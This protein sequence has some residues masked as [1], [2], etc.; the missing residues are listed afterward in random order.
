MS[1]FL[2]HDISYAQGQYNM[3]ADPYPAIEMKMSGYYYGSKTPYL[4]VQAARNYSNAIRLGKVPILYHYAGG[5]DPRAEAEYFINVCAPLAAGDVYELDYELNSS[6]GPPADPDGWCRAFADRVHELTG[7][8]PIFYTYTSLFLQHNKF[9]KTMEVCSLYIAD[10][11]FTPDQN[12]PCG[13]PYIM[14]QY[15]DSPVDTNASFISL[16]TLRKYAYGYQEP[17]PPPPAPEPTTT[18]TTVEPAPE[19]TTTTTT[20]EAP[21]PPVPDPTTTTTT[22]EVMEPPTSTTTTT[23]TQPA[24]EEKP[25]GLNL[26]Q[27]V[28]ARMFHT[29]W[30]SFTAIFLLGIS[31]LTSTLLSV[32]SLSDAKSAAYAVA[33]AVVA[34]ALSAFKNL[35]APPKEVK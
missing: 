28:L 9:P 24:I 30:Q 22:T 6:M 27:A 10:Y 5:A 7:K 20:T 15:S 35:I 11:R 25:W 19:P 8:Y 4:D 17:T 16:D 13:H 32:H 18:T 26:Y 31:G 33:A 1:D 14:H 12:V 29:F 23:T 21:A 3:D 2:F 34:A